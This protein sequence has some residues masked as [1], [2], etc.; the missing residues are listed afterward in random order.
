MFQDAQSVY[1]GIVIKQFYQSTFS[2]QENEYTVN[3]FY[4]RMVV[5]MNKKKKKC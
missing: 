1:F 2:R 5:N 4:R 3:Y